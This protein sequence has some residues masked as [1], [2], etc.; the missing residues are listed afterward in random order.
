MAFRSD[1][2]GITNV[3]TPDT[4]ATYWVMPLDLS[5]WR[6]MI[7]HGQYPDARF[8]NFSS[9]IANSAFIDTISDERIVPDPGKTN[10]FAPP[11]TEI[12]GSYT[13]T[14]SAAN[15]GLSNFLTTGG[16]RFALIVYRIYLPDKGKDRS[17]SVSVPV[18]TFTDFSGNSRTLGPAHLPTQRRASGIWYFCSNLWEWR[19]ARCGSA[20]SSAAA[21]ARRISH[22]GE[23]WSRGC[24]R[25]LTHRPQDSAVSAAIRVPLSRGRPISN[26]NGRD[27]SISSSYATEKAF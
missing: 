26:R 24:R 6:A 9:Y 16:S 20:W 18:V 15:P 3:V 19:A 13:V 27:Q 17:G 25:E 23:G 12:A 4:N 2:R 14:I 11:D 8:F 1:R 5:R 22:P 10:P 21:Y 7:I